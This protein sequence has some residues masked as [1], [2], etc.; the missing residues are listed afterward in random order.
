MNCHTSG[1]PNSTW[2][3]THPRGVGTLFLFTTHQYKAIHF[4]E[5][6]DF[7]MVTFRGKFNWTNVFVLDEEDIAEHEVALDVVDL[8]DVEI[9]LDLR[10]SYFCFGLIDLLL[11]FDEKLPSRLGISDHNVSRN[12]YFYLQI[13]VVQ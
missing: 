10:Y 4:H 7:S 9:V 2:D 1:Q 11:P 5:W 3:H 6:H 8:V 12:V 13:A